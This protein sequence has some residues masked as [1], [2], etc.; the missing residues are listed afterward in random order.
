M[1][2][3]ACY[4][5]SLFLAFTLCVSIG[6][7]KPP[8]RVVSDSAFLTDVFSYSENYRPQIDLNGTWEF[9]RDP[10][11]R[12]KK[13]E[14][15]VGK[16]TFSDTMTIPGAPQS[17]GFGEPDTWRKNYFEGPF[18]VR[19]AFDLPGFDSHQ[20]V[21]LRIGG[22][23]PA[24]EIYLNGE[25]VGYTKSSRTQQR[26]DVT[27]FVKPSSA[28]LIAIKVCDHPEVRLDGLWEMVELRTMWTG[29]YRPIACE[30]TDRVS[31]LDAYIQPRLLSGSA[32]VDVDLSASPTEPLSLLFQVKDG[33]EI[34]GRETVSISRRKKR[35]GCDIE[36]ERFETWSPEHP[37]LYTLEITLMKDGSN[38]P[39][40][41][42]GIQFGMR[43]V[44]TNG[45]KFYL[46]GK[47]I[48]I[49]CYGEDQFYLDTIC[50]PADKQWYL[51]RLKC[52][53]EYGMNA[54]K[55]CVETVPQEY[56]EAADEAGI[57]VI[58]EMPFGLSGLRANRYTI[59]ERFREFY[60][61]ELDGL[62]RESRNHASVIAYS[63]SSEM[64]FS[65]QTQES[66][67]F[68]SRD[69]VRQTRKLAPH[70]LLIDC[71]GYLDGE[72]TSKGK[73][74]TDFY[75]HII[76]TWMKEV[77]DETP[78][79]TDRKHP[80]LLHEYNWW[81]CYPNPADKEK[82][83]KTQ[84]KP[85]WLDT[86]VRSAWEN[87]Q[88]E[89]IPTYRK[90]S[91]WLQALCRKDGVEYARRNPDVEGYILWLLVDFG[92]YSEGLLDDFWNPKNV[93]AEEF[94]Q[95]NGDTVI[96]LAKE[97]NRCLMM[98]R[99]ARIPLAV[100]HYGEEEYPNSSLQWT[101][102]HESV[103]GDGVLDIPT[104]Q[105]GELTQAGCAEF[106]LPM[107]EK[108]YKFE[109]EV[110]LLHEGNVVNINNWSFWAF[111]EVSGELRQ[112]ADGNNA[113]ETIKDG[114]FL[115]LNS[116]RSAPIPENSPLVIADCVDDGL[117][118]YIKSGGQC[119]LFSRG[120]VIENTKEYV[121]SRSFYTTFRTIP[122]NAGNSG[123][124][125]S[126][127]NHHPALESFPH[128]GMCDLQFIWMV[129]DVLPMEFEPLR[130]YGVY[131]IIRMIDHYAANRNNAHM[132]EFKVG[133]GK[134]LVTTLGVLDKLN[135]HIEARYLLNCLVDYARGT[136]FDPT[137]V[138]PKEALLKLFSLRSE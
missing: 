39:V 23:L 64:E 137:A 111:P 113:G 60:S 114:V 30:I 20:R 74:E 87:G 34:I 77:L 37:K 92:Q 89:M 126:V 16:G 82:Y 62:V 104:L 68:F 121:T 127:I 12:G 112:V 22:I 128:E 5:L 47:P 75:A 88:G 132:L 55:S 86:L 17:Q 31:V 59:D 19:R 26:V 48:Y 42:V 66:F 54:V 76:P 52:A 18:W 131:P 56:I 80:V 79:N 43:E 24:A 9:G 72:D 133:E 97:G 110:A 25:Y 1:R 125:G 91:L 129:R 119:L 40:D 73:R 21:W 44:M 33:R 69:L 67:E 96:V 83:A 57:M 103:F 29:V 46:N 106:D 105:Q 85:F 120:A 84:I 95:S 53:R 15:H 7:A 71:T 6:Q 100:S 101:V 78:I 136:D 102:T 8:E 107:A 135:S 118:E 51:S 116:A 123:N 130:E 122:W 98:G 50:P 11:D 65:N 36:L 3:F 38:T 4:S 99:K 108:A 138:V 2:P 94:L 93:S 90:N 14:W 63:M 49:R 124:S 134:V 117:A 28:N 10:D 41:K 70:A 115:R 35:A 61:K 32:R 13:Q 81:S 45:T 27:D 58:Q 109:M